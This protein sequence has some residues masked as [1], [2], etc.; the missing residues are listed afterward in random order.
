MGGVFVD[1]INEEST[2]GR[3]LRFLHFPSAYPWIAFATIVV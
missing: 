3:R 2:V 1:D